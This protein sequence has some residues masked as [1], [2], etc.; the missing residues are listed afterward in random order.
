MDVP[1]WLRKQPIGTVF[2]HASPGQMADSW[3]KGEG[4]YRRTYDWIRFKAEDFEWTY[5]EPTTPVEGSITEEEADALEERARR[6]WG[7]PN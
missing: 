2:T 6:P 3:I 4:G 1:S 5:V 7:P